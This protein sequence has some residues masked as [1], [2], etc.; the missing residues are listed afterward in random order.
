MDAAAGFT[1]PK[2]G[3][4]SFRNENAGDTA[5]PYWASSPG[6]AGI[7]GVGFDAASNSIGAR[8]RALRAAGSARNSSSVE[9]ASAGIPAG[10]PAAAAV[11]GAL[12]SESGIAGTVATGLALP[13]CANSGRAVKN[14]FAI[15]A[16]TV[17]S[18]PRSAIHFSSQTGAA[19]SFIG[20]AGLCRASFGVMISS[21]FD[22]FQRSNRVVREYRN[23][24]IERNQIGGDSLRV[25]PH[26]PDRQARRLFSGQS[27]LKQSDDALLLFAHAQQQNARFASVRFRF[28]VPVDVQLFRGKDWNAAPGQEWRT[29]QRHR[30]RRH[31]A[32]RALA[33]K[34]CNRARMRQKKRRLLPHLGEQ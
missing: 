25:D 1:A 28:R 17:G 18:S 2:I 34:C 15:R 3:L 31:A 30:R 9:K 12:A 33:S 26:E 10:S 5:D 16:S 21:D 14:S 6:M 7:Q 24:A 23:R 13:A 27:R 19:E 32:K 4:A 22:V 11:S 8:A 29:K 20:P